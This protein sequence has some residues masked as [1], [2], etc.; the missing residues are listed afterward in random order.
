MDRDIQAEIDADIRDVVGTVPGQGQDMAI[1][2]AYEG[3]SQFDQWLATWEASTASADVDMLGTKQMADA[4]SRDVLRN[5]GYIQSGAN[6]TKDNIVGASYLLNAKPNS[7][8][9]GLDE[10]WEEEFQQEVEAKFTL[11]A[12]SPRCWFD[13]SRSKTFTGMI[14]LAVGIYTYAGEI[15]AT[16]DWV[17]NDRTRPFKTAVQ[18]IDLDRLANPWSSPDVMGYGVYDGRIVRGGVHQDKFGAPIGYYIRNAHPSE[19]DRYADI[20]DFTYVPVSKPWGRL[21]VMHLK[22]EVRAGQTRAVADVVAGL[23]TIKITSKFRDLTLQ[24]AAVN[25]MIAASIES[26][27]PPE[28]AFAALGGGKVTSP[29]E[30]VGKYGREY[31]EAITKF[32]GKRGIT[33]DNVKI[34]HFFPGTRLNLRNSGAPGGVGQEFEQSLLRHTAAILGVSYEQLSK[35]YSKTNY[36]SARAG[37]N[38]T[39]KFMQG[40]KKLVADRFATNIYMLWFEEMMNAG[41][42]EAMKYSKAPNYYEGI[43]AEAYTSCDWIGAARGQIDELKETQAAVLR[44][45]FGLGTHEDELAKMGKDWR[46]VYK[47]LEREQKERDAR[48]IVLQEDNS[49]NAASGSPREQDKQNSDGADANALAA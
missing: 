20:N 38:E 1:G 5:D 42:I 47:Q 33:V 24:Q 34:P 8:V 40:R 25:A 16:S 45:K 14:R 28:A 4:R 41:E 48:G 17:R 12:E 23:K 36:S 10:V 31:L 27:L 15:L 44:I 29:G 9:L 11:A 39:W 46:K 18:M 43:N 37:F 35:D 2:G 13:R 7:E 3:A 19:F 49:V 21:Q 32:V 26:D 30:V 22:E 6:I